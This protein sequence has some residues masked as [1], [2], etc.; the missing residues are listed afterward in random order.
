MFLSR[1]D[2]RDDLDF[3]YRKATDWHVG[4][5]NADWSSL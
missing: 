1:F 5:E 3:E 4:I 2:M